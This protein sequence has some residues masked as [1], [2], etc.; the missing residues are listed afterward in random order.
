MFVL[1]C[2]RC[3]DPVR[4][5]HEL[6]ERAT[7]RCPLCHET[8]PP[9]ELAGLLPPVLMYAD[10][11]DSFSTVGGDFDSE[12]DF[13][14]DDQE[15]GNNTTTRGW[16]PSPGGS[17]LQGGGFVVDD[18]MD[19]RYDL[20]EST[21]PAGVAV[22]PASVQTGPTR[23]KSGGGWKQVV[24]IVLGGALALPLA[25][26]LLLAVGKAPDLGV[27]PFDGTYN[28]GLSQPAADRPLPVNSP[29][30]SSV[31]PPDSGGGAQPQPRP[32][33]SGQSLAAEL[34]D[35]P[36]IDPAEAAAA[37]IMNPDAASQLP[38]TEPD[39]DAVPESSASNE[40]ADRLEISTGTGAAPAQVPP[41]VELPAMSI[42]DL[43]PPV[44][45]DPPPANEP[46]ANV[47]QAIDEFDGDVAPVTEAFIAASDQPAGEV[48][49][50]LQSILNDRNL[51]LAKALARGASETVNDSAT[52]SAVVIGLVNAQGNRLQLTDNQLYP[53][54]GGSLTSGA[55]IVALVTID[56]DSRIPTL[57][58]VHAATR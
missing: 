29:V 11:S 36:A 14:V 51:A 43:A 47:R 35:G 58:V 16:E 8:I 10:D 45:P 17:D 32:A 7:M 39:P 24:G 3:D 4:L 48:E 30:N 13:G 26:G 57:N 22:A 46:L 50:L 40:P 23:K 1:A 55:T 41:V 54:A 21:A 25:G 37:A 18:E 19:P 15:T 44:T 33:A 56:H 52:P 5:P 34:G 12:P 28:G 2:P 31:D 49:P 9:H 20:G 27:W 6:D 38:A 42:D 53:L